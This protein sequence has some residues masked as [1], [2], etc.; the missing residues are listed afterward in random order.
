MLPNTHVNNNYNIILI[1]INYNIVCWKTILSLI[2]V[3]LQ[4]L[5]TTYCNICNDNVN[6]TLP[7]QRSRVGVDRDAQTP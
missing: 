4:S 6:A 2:F 7:F 1:I 3:I 5:K